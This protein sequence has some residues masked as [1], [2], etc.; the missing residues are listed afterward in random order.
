M[1]QVGQSQWIFNKTDGF[2]LPLGRNRGTALT[3]SGLD[4]ARSRSGAQFL[5][6]DAGEFVSI[7]GESGS[8]K[9]TL[10][11]AL[12]GEVSPEK[13]RIYVND[14]NGEYDI[15]I[16]RDRYRS[17]LGYLS[18]EAIVHKELTPLEILQFSDSCGE[19]ST[20]GESLVKRCEGSVFSESRWESPLRELSGGEQQRI[21][22]ASELVAEPLFSLDEPASGLDREHEKQLARSLP[23]LELDRLHGDHGDSWR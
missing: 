1:V 16:G 5:H 2:L 18:Q 9:S 15:E 17:I 13:N 8:G 23:A 19:A 10:L 22:I 14:G 3:V 12:A 11:K 4:I 20:I 21:R 7:V 6:V